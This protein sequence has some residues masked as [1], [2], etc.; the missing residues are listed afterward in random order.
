VPPGTIAHWPVN[1]ELGGVRLRWATA[2]PLTVLDP[3]DDPTLVLVAEAGIPVEL[4]ADGASMTDAAGSTR[5]VAPGVFRV[6][7]AEPRGVDVV[8]GDARLRVLVLPAASAHDLWVLDAPDGRRLVRSAAPVHLDDDGRLAVRS[9]QPPDVEAFD[10]SARAFV[11]VAVAVDASGPG[12]EVALA[13][14]PIDVGEPP[15]ATYG[16]RAGRAAAPDAAAIARHGS[17][18]SLRLPDAAPGRAVLHVD[19]AGDASSSTGS[20]TARRGRSD[21]THSTSR[22]VPA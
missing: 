14:E 5:G 3:R 1:L 11:A 15:P 12:A 22:P 21:S 9:P 16:E 10:V 20:G 7:A 13:P 17:T 2:S 6:D 8:Q 4:A 19:W 18:W